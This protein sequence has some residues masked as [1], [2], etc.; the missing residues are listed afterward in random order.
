LDLD[1]IQ[2][3]LRDGVLRVALTKS[4]RVQPRKITVS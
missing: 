3:E 4:E 1:K 2:A